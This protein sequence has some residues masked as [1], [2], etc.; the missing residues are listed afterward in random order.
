[1]PLANILVY[2]LSDAFNPCNLSTM[3][4]FVALLDWLRRRHLPYVSLGWIF[5]VISYVAAIIFSAGGLMNILYSI[6]FFKIVRII[7][8]VIGIVFII[9]GII[10]LA[11]WIR[12][13]RGGL[14]KVLLPLSEGGKGMPFSRILGRIG[15]IALAVCLNAVSTIW[16]SNAFISFYSNYIS[17]PGE[18]KSTLIMLC[19]YNLMLTVP[20][21]LAMYW[22]PWSSSSGWVAKAPAKAK[23]VLSAF[24]LGLGFGLVYIFH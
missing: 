4:M 3:V 19:I 24:L 14:S 13:K 1:M 21:I 16:P 5:I 2:G 6:V 7:Y 10:H 8:V 22:I 9:I 11:D 20:L 12:I 23:I 17:V 15:V 18:I